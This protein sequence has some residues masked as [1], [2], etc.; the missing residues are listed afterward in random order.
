MTA[1]IGP[2]GAGKSSLFGLISGR[3]QPTEGT[4]RVRGPV[5]E[6]LQTTEINEQLRLSVE[7]VVRFGRYPA[8]GFLGPMRSGDRAIIDAAL[9]ATNLTDLR[10]RPISELSGGQ[11]Q[12]A[13][14]AQAL[15]QQAP[16][17]L[18]DEPTAGLDHRSQKELLG[19]VKAVAARGT[20][21][22]YATHNLDEVSE[23]DNLIVLACACVC[24]APPTDALADPA[25][26]ELFGPAPKMAWNDRAISHNAEP[27]LEPATPLAG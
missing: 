26:T 9:A 5:A 19:I 11:R 3:L 4:V 1:V 27:G 8:R 23:A 16:V 2:N 18:L 12:R 14:I 13:L 25:V 20:T 24:C 21:V 6:V 10:R 22:L 17:L 7:S 15:A